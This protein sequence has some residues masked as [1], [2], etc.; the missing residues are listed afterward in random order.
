MSF[1][2]EL[3]IF[4]LAFSLTALFPSANAETE[5]N[6]QPVHHG[7]ASYYS[8]KYHGKKTANGELYNKYD[9]TAATHSTFPFGTLLRVVN[10]RNQKSVDVRVTS[11][12]HPHNK[13]L[14]DLSKQA[15]IQLGFLQA[16]TTE[17]AITVLRLGEA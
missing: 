11:R 8:D 15:A 13:R 10:L 14:V 12:V 5:K 2:K 9:L 7:V 17:V 3:V 1:N 16:G 4:F 6:D